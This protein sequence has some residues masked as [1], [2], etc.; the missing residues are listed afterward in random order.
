MT[1]TETTNDLCTPWTLHFDGDGTEV[2]AV[3][4]NAAGDDLIA[5]RPFW[6]PAGDDPTPPTLAA[7]LAMKA[8]P[9]LL[10]ALVKCEAKLKE[11]HGFVLY[12]D[13]FLHEQEDGSLAEITE[14]CKLA[15]AAINEASEM[16][17]GW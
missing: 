9:N 8:A 11:F 6:Q 16:P 3:I 12:V 5:S 15:A 2:I 13:Q 7:V 10:A 14:V 4:R 17:A 1:E